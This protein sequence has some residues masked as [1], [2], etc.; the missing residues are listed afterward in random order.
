MEQKIIYRAKDGLFNYVGWP[1]VAKDERC[2]KWK[3]TE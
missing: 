3:L 1:T 2:T